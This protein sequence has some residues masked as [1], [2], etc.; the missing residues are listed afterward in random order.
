MKCNTISSH[1][2]KG[3]LLLTSHTKGEVCTKAIMSENPWLG[4]G[5]YASVYKL[6]TP[7]HYCLRLTHKELSQNQIQS[8]E[9][10][11]EVQFRLSNSNDPR[12]KL[13]NHPCK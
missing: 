10:G 11:F 4:S 8:E 5:G 6:D 1:R 2:K 7:E 13:I 9:K 12:K 3:T